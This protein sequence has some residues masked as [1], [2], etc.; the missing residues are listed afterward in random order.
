MDISYQPVKDS[1]TE[2]SKEDDSNQS[3]DA[4]SEETSD[5]S[6]EEYAT[7]PDHAAVMSEENSNPNI[8]VPIM[9]F[10]QDKSSRKLVRP[11]KAAVADKAKSIRATNAAFPFLKPA[12][13]PHVYSKWEKK[14]DEELCFYSLSVA[15]I[16]YLSGFYF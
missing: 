12:S 7:D 2:E 3:D 6:P 10:M 13:Q 8:N 9:D 1:E 14:T 5:S 15:S 16:T 11:R 4:T